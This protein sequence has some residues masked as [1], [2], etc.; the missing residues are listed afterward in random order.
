MNNDDINKNILVRLVEI[1]SILEK[2]YANCSFIYRR[3]EITKDAIDGYQLAFSCDSYFDPIF[4]MF[5]LSDY[6]VLQLQVECERSETD[7]VIISDGDVEVLKKLPL[8]DGADELRKFLSETLGYK[9]KPRQPETGP[10][11]INEIDRQYFVSRDRWN[12]YWASKGLTG[13]DSA[14][15]MPTYA[16]IC[17]ATPEF[18]K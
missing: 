2:A 15:T 14:W 12:A 13:P 10:I 3:F 5:A 11:L 18:N 7:R 6:G 1:K 17:A 8:Q 4:S 16:A 9:P